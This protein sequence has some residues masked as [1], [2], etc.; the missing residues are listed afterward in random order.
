MRPPAHRGLRLRPGGNEEK[1]TSGCT[2]RVISYWLFVIS[3]W[4]LGAGYWVLDAGYGVRVAEYGIWVAG[5][6]IADFRFRIEK[7]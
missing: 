6:S 4:M 3:Y 7:I 2:M 5:Y 1:K